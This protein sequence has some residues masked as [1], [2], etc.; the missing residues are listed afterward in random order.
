MAKQRKQNKEEEIMENRRISLGFGT[1]CVLLT[2]VFLV[3]K[4]CNVINW[5]WVFVFMPI[6]VNVGIWVLLLVIYVAVLIITTLVKR[7]K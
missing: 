3:L 7:N 4:L 5:A 6:I 1:I 2:I